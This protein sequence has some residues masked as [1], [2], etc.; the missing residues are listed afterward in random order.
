MQPELVENDR[1]CSPT[2]I[3][4]EK[5]GDITNG[6]DELSRVLTFAQEDPQAFELAQQMCVALKTQ[7]LA[8]GL[9]GVSDLV[10][11]AD[12]MLGLIARGGARNGYFWDRVRGSIRDAVRLAEFGPDTSPRKEAIVGARQKPLLVIDDDEVFLRLMRELARRHSIPIVTATSVQEGLNAIH[13]LDISA[14]I[15]DVHLVDGTSFRHADEIRERVGKQDLTII[16]ASADGALETRLSACS[17]GADRYLD[18]PI[19]G[20]KFGEMVHQVPFCQPS[21]S[22]IVIL[23]DD[24]I[25]L[26][27]YESELRSA[28]H[29]V[30]GVSNSSRLLDAL[31]ETKPDALL[32]DVNLD[33]GLSGIDVCRAIR[34]SEQ[35]QFLP[36]LMFSSDRDVNMR[37]RAFNAGAS[38]VLAKPLGADELIARVSAQTER[39]RLMR[40]RSDKDVLSGLMTRRAFVESIQRSLAVGAREN[41][42]L[43]LTLFDLDNFKQINDMHGHAV[44]DRVIAAFGRLLRE[45][46]R[47]EDLRGRWGGEEFVLAFP[48]QGADFGMSTAERLLSEFRAIPIETESGERIHASFTAGVASV[49]EDGES[50]DLLMKTADQRLYRGKNAGRSR[51]IGPI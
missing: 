1:G 44:G 39:V 28:G 9:Q 20:Q 35:W 31:S 13:G 4:D 41:K 29:H 34:T 21:A 17:A 10:G 36:I 16:F 47:I 30:V 26:E 7:A 42:P 11:K 24:E 51:V 32:L 33:S 22:R 18:K 43:S 50:L 8:H 48:G 23:D 49:P 5:P 38:D 14:V 6:L 19:S 40:E 15:L 12:D 45:R 27:R 37:V 2:E 25:V 3:P 46:F